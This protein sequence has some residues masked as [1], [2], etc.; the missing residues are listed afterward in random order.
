MITGDD[1]HFE[2]AN[3]PAGKYSLLGAKRGYITAAYDQHEQFSTA[4]VT[5]AGV[6]TENLNLRLASTAVITGH[7]F[8]E[9]GEP[10]RNASVTLWRDDHSAGVSRT[11]PV[12]T[13]QCDDQGSFEFA[14]ARCRHLLR[15]RRRQAVVCGTR[16]V[17]SSNGRAGYSHFRRSFA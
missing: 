6:D 1:G 4:I 8:D 17:D 7:V 5:G 10:V 13:D 16:A 11:V 9:F 15:L 2:F 14:P 3:L 12:Q